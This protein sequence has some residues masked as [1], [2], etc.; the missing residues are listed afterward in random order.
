MEQR[1]GAATR[2]LLKRP[3][4]VAQGV[5]TGVSLPEGTSTVH[6]SSATGALPLKQEGD[7][8]KSAEC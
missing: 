6:L 2:A 5:G 3:T 7:P 1:L 4:C 8:L